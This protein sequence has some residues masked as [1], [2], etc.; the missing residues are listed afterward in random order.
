MAQSTSVA[1]NTSAWT[2]ILSSGTDIL[3]QVR[4]PGDALIYFG[5]SPP[6][7]DDLGTFIVKRNDDQRPFELHGLEAGLNVYAK[8]VTAKSTITVLSYTGV[9]GG[10][11]GGGGGGGDDNEWGGVEW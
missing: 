8:A 6:D 10:G 9:V 2:Q 1:L 11:G 4:G 7:A 3:V 5:S